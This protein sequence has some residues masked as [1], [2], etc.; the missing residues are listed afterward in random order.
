MVVARRGF[1][2]SH[3]EARAMTSMDEVCVPRLLASRRPFKSHLSNSQLNT[4][5]CSCQT[6][7]LTRMRAVSRKDK[8]HVMAVL[9]EG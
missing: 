5:P 1:V 4:F 3:L 7:P 9:F 6:L 8:A 2:A